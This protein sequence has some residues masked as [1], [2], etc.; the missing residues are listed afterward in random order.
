[1]PPDD[2]EPLDTAIQQLVNNEF[3][4]LILT[5]ANTVY[6]LEARLD[7]LGYS[8]HILADLDLHVAVVGSKTAQSAQRR[9]G[10][11]IDTIPEE[12]IAE[13]LA[14]SLAELDNLHGARFFLPQSSIAPPLLNELLLE[15]GVQ[16]ACV[17][18][19][20]TQLA[21][22]GD[23]LLPQ[24]FEVDAITFTSGSTARNFL[25]RFAQEAG[26]VDDLDDVVVACIGPKAAKKAMEWA[27]DV[28]VIAEEH[29]LEGMLDALV[30]YFENN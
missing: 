3:D 8:P 29:T 1:M 12:F 9:L 18:A 15:L 2:L 22:S 11:S 26:D 13:A 10:L 28:R 4:A 19:Y 7:E 30:D 21:T 17:P 6:A 20:K 5:S 27:F 16:V 24:I 14:E 25:K 23:L